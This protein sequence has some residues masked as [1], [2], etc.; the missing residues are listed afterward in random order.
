MNIKSKSNDYG[1]PL[2]DIAV[3]VAVSAAAFTVEVAIADILPWGE[4]ARGIIAVL[5]GAVAAV[6]LTL[7]RGAALADLGFQRPKRW[8]TVP[9]WALGIFVVFV[10][11]QGVVPVLVANFIDV[12]QPDMSRYD[13]IRG[14]LPAAITMGLALPLTAAIPEEI[15]YRG[16]LINRLIALFGQG[17]AGGTLA[18]VVQALI[19]GAVHFQ[20]GVGGVFVTAIMGLVWGFAFLLC[21]RNLWIVIIAHSMAHVALVMQIYSSP[22]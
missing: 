19:F 17:R 22:A 18:V 15:V 6:V 8:L 5:S 1:R 20:W 9:F 7:I 11:A 3:V 10:V 21:G 13:Y 12:P 16:F 14:N 4:E 2:V